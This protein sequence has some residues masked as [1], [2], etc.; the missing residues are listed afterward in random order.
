M[1]AYTPLQVIENFSPEALSLNIALR[2]DTPSANRM[3]R[4]GASE[5]YPFVE[6]EVCHNGLDLAFKSTGLVL[7]TDPE[8]LA[9]R[10]EQLEILV[11]VNFTEPALQT[12]IANVFSPSAQIYVGL[13]DSIHDAV[14]KSSSALLVR[15]VN[16]VGTVTKTIRRTFKPSLWGNHVQSYRTFLTTDITQILSENWMT[17][18][19]AVIPQGPDISTARISFATSWTEWK[20]LEDCPNESVFSSLASV[21]GLWTFL[22][23]MFAAIYGTSIVKVLF[24]FKPMS[25][26]GYVHG[27]QKSNLRQAYLAEYPRVQ[28]DLK[29]R[30]EDRGL[31]ALIHDHILDIDFLTPSKDE[32]NTRISNSIDPSPDW[33]RQKTERTGQRELECAV[34]EHKLVDTSAPVYPTTLAPEPSI[35]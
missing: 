6:V 18:F 8:V 3:A 35:S 20:I 25:V 15:G 17:P 4:S 16:L 32:T 2:F 10:L 34:V 33:D 29:A 5:L 7:S 24:E 1:Y 26:F 14:T 11:T 31:L 23:G 21:G 22:A 9:E 19:K 30:T 13:T 28:E 27:L 12:T